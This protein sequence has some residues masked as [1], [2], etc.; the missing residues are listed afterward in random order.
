MAQSLCKIYIH[1]I[2][3]IKT[4]S[5]HICEEDL[6]R[7]HAYIGQLVNK[8]GCVN[9]WVGGIEDHVHALCL[10]SREET[11]SHLVEEIKRKYFPVIPGEDD[12]ESDEGAPSTEEPTEEN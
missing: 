6:L 10:L 1:M 3:H 11:I 8:T 7:I 9:I 5:P 4:T 12:G 2:F